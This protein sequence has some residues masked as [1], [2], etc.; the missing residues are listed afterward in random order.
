MAEFLREMI[1][2][3]KDSGGRVDEVLYQQVM[4]TIEQLE[5]EKKRNAVKVLKHRKGIPTVIEWCG[6]R[7]TFDAGSTFRGGVRRGKR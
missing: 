5:E 1:S 7:F 4:K 2:N 6:D 3:Y